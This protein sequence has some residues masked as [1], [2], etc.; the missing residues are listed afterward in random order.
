M[1]FIQMIRDQIDPDYTL[2]AARRVVVAGIN[3]SYA[4]LLAPNTVDAVSLQWL[5]N[6]RDGV[7]SHRRL[8]ALL[9]RLFRRR[10]KKTSNLRVTGFLGEFAGDR[11]SP[12]QKASNA[13]NVS[14]WWRHHVRNKVPA[15]GF[16]LHSC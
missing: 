11:Q 4:V 13:E 12:S 7:S 16:Y 3:L 10:S 1:L 15:C 5:H 14:I 8:D 6:G 2:K 9:N